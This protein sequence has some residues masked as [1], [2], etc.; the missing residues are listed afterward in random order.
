MIE[1]RHAN[2]QQREFLNLTAASAVYILLLFIPPPPFISQ[3]LNQSGWMILLFLAGIFA[4]LLYQK[5][6]AWEG[7]QYTFVFALFALLLVHQWQFAVNYGEII[8]GLLPWSDA[9]GYLQEAQWL[10]NGSLFTSFGARRP[11]FAAFLAVLLQLTNRNFMVTLALLTWVNALAVLLIVREVRRTHGAIGVSILLILAYKFYLRFAGTT[12]TEQL[13]FALGNLA[14]YFLLIGAQNKDLKSALTGLAVLSLALNARAGAFLILPML[15][16]WCVIIFT[17]TKGSWRTLGLSIAVVTLPFLLNS[18]L[19]RTITDQHGAPFSNYSN[20]LYGLASGNKGWT[21]VYDDHPD[22]NESEIMPLALQKIRSDPMLLMRGMLGAYQDYFTPLGGAFTFIVY[23][24]Y[25]FRT[26]ANIILWCLTLTGLIH[27]ALN[28]KKGSHAL[29]FVSFIG[30]FASVSRVPPADADGMRVYATTLPFTGL[31]VVEGCYALLTWDKQLLKHKGESSVEESGYPAQRMAIGF[32]ALLVFLPIPAPLLLRSLA[33]RINGADKPAPQS[34]C[35]T[36]QQPLNLYIIKNAR[37]VLIPNEAAAESLM[38]FIR[39]GDFKNAILNNFSDIP[40]LGKELQEMQ[41]GQQISLGFDNNTGKYWLISSLPIA[42]GRFSACGYP[43]ENEKLHQNNFFTMKGPLVRASFLTIPQQYPNLTLLIRLLYGLGSLLI[44][45][46]AVLAILRPR[47]RSMPENIYVICAA[48][49]MIQGVL[50]ALYSQA[51]LT[52]PFAEQRITL[53]VN[54]AVPKKPTHL[55]ILP[56]GINW[57]NQADLGFWPA[58][59]YEDGIPLAAPNALH[60]SIRDNGNGGFSVWNGSLYFSS[61][62]NTN[63][64]TNGR[65]YELT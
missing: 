16:L 10:L 37:I 35:I 52:L 49:L 50:V 23:S 13:G 59:V 21:Q 26:K 14:V 24:L 32:T 27:A 57:M 36:G 53:D 55:F 60:Q 17:K 8:G 20:T 25:S 58:V 62:D 33:G 41:A 61:S 2:L 65:K 30:V 1:I 42:P 43:T 31:W 54:D 34:T 51:I 15:I 6:T 9:S 19:F 44:I 47:L 4:L 3:T 63:P 40:F 28:W 18:L 39:I 22:I 7:I 5:G 56:L 45:I 46:L 29:L 38:P 64:R 48:L 11:L 12:M